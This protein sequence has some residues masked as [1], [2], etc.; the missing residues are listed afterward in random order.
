MIKQ[1]QESLTVFREYKE[2][3]KDLEPNTNLVLKRVELHASTL[4]SVSWLR[5]LLIRTEVNPAT[6]HWMTFQ[7]CSND[8]KG[9]PKSCSPAHT[10]SSREWRSAFK[11]ARTIQCSGTWQD[12]KHTGAR[13]S[14]WTDNPKSMEMYK[15]VQ[16]GRVKMVKRSFCITACL[17]HCPL[18]LFLISSISLEASDEILGNT[19]KNPLIKTLQ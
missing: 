14:F 5:S 12:V 19:N 16:Q 7:Q 4:A 8:S 3:Q 10:A 18:S 17:S 1:I 2:E 11:R 6:E 9:S 15:L 13:L